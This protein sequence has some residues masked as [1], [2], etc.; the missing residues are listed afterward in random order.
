MQEQKPLQFTEKDIKNGKLPDPEQVMEKLNGISVDDRTEERFERTKTERNIGTASVM[1]AG[2]TILGQQIPAPSMGVISLLNIINSPFVCP[3]DRELNVQD[4]YDAMYILC[5]KQEALNIV[6]SGQQKTK[7]IEKLEKMVKDKDTFLTYSQLFILC[8]YTQEFK[9][10][11]F[12]FGETLG[13]FD[14]GEI[15]G[16]I[17]DYLNICMYGY[18][19]LESQKKMTNQ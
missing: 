5:K 19:W 3:Q 9:T 10:K 7:Q 1:G 8:D 12:E 4:I 16:Q 11:A 2:T 15:G 14:I 18:S 17:L 13:I 6:T